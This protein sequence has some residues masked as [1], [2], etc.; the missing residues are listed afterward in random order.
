MKKRISIFL[1]SLIMI[2]IFALPV[3]AN[4][5]YKDNYYDGSEDYVQYD[6][7][8]E[9]FEAFEKTIVLDEWY[10]WFNNLTPEEQA[11]INYRPKDFLETQSNK[12]G[13]D[14]TNKITVIQVDPLM[15]TNDTKS[16]FFKTED[17][18]IMATLPTSGWELPYN[19]SF[20][21]SSSVRPY[22]NCYCYALNVVT[23][24]Q[25]GMNPGDLAG[26]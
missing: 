1:L 25:G 24:T 21:N 10:E 9:A 7:L 14:Y 4:D 18:S 5:S 26:K 22:A 6:N 13:I 2:L 17:M 20:W 12:Y 19:P 3:Y 15:T 8:A 11:T 16:D 23:N